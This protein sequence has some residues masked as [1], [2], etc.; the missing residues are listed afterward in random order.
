MRVRVSLRRPA[1]RDLD[2]ALDWYLGTAPEYAAAFLDEVGQ[3]I[4]RIGRSLLLFRQVHGELRRAAL[5]RYPYF[6]W[7]VIEGETAHVIAISHKRQ[8]PE[9]VGTRIETWTE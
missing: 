2:E 4:Q 1:E 9:T 7:Y 6:V 8:D 3:V 5:R